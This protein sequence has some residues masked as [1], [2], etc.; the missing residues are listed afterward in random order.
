M[1]NLLDD[2]SKEIE[3]IFGNEKY[4][5]RDN[6]AVMRF[7]KEGGRKR[8]L[9]NIWTFGKVDEKTGKTTIWFTQRLKQLFTTRIE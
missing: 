6:G 5:V 8:Q 3:C 9:D 2:F 7:P 1:N 4:S